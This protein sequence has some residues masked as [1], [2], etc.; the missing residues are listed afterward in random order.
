V[1]GDSLGVSKKVRDVID[2][3]EVGT[4]ASLRRK[5]GLEQLR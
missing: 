5:T 3:M 1:V 2:A 4:L